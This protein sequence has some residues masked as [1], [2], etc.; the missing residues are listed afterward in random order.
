M[1]ENGEWVQERHPGTEAR[2][3]RVCGE[4]VEEE[5]RY[6]ILHTHPVEN[7][8]KITSKFVIQLFNCVY[9]I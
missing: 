3:R 7:L 6:C 5:N 8:T 9:T 4:C 1:E 2:K